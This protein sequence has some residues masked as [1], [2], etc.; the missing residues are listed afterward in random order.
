VVPASLPLY[1][2][3]ITEGAWWDFVDDTATHM[4]RGLV[5]GFPDDIW[6]TVEAWNDD[7]DLWLRRTSIICQ[8]GAKERTDGGRLFTFCEKR[9]GETDFFI[10]KAIGWAL[11]E[12]ART[13]PEAVAAF[14]MDNRETLSALSFREATKHIGDLIGVGGP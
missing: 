1:H 8:V 4:I 6:P 13:D 14:A 2:R 9:M 5:L 10:R 3:F 7:A 11:R 12:Y